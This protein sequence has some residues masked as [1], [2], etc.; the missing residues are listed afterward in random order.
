[1]KPVFGLFMV[2][3]I[4]GVP[5]VLGV[6]PPEML[7]WYKVKTAPV[8]EFFSD[9]GQSMKKHTGPLVDQVSKVA[10]AV[11]S[12]P[13]KL[14]DIQTAQTRQENIGNMM[15]KMVG[16][17]EL[18]DLENTGPL[19]IS[20]D[21]MAQFEDANGLEH[22]ALEEKTAAEAHKEH[23]QEVFKKSVA[24]NNIYALPKDE[25]K[26]VADAMPAP[27]NITVKDTSNLE[28]KQVAKVTA[29]V[30][31]PEKFVPT[32][33]VNDIA[34]KTEFNFNMSKEYEKPLIFEGF[35]K[36]ISPEFIKVGENPV[37]LYGIRADS[38]IAKRDKA[39]EFASQIIGNSLVTCKI[40]G[41]TYDN[42]P[43]G[44]CS[45]GIINI[46]DTLVQAKLVSLSGN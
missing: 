5:Y 7:G 3:V 10:D 44:I 30:E 22:G 43:A 45:A 6:K 32:I 46:N 16:G 33:T 37:Y 18:K 1:M 15:S 35:A 26:H 34:G 21:D 11:V 17:S 8:R 13:Q 25:V 40:M 2:L 41:L 19:N 36:V 29:Q 42:I 39:K 14:R 38:D 28:P 12:A 4:I 31:V 24:K 23:M 9:Y 27:L 20:K